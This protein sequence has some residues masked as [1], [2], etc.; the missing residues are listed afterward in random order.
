MMTRRNPT[1]LPL[2][3]KVSGR[4]EAVQTDEGFVPYAFG[5]W[6]PG[7]SLSMTAGRA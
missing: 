5:N 4:P 3:E 2:R 7:V 6:P 1:L